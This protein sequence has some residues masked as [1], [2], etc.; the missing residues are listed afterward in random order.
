MASANITSKTAGP[1]KSMNFLIVSM[2]LRK[3][4]GS[5]SHMNKKL[6]QPVSDRRRA[7][8]ARSGNGST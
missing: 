5:N 1:Q 2:P 7:R 8:Q 3:I 4:K 6:A